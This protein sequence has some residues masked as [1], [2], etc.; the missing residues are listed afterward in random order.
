M[1]PVPVQ[2]ACSLGYIHPYFRESPTDKIV[3]DFKG[4]FGQK[5]K[6]KKEMYL[7]LWE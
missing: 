4:G 2:I 1:I 6:E 5:R 7:V 3:L